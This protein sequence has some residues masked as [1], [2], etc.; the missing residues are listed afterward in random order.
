MKKVFILLLTIGFLSSGFAQERATVVNGLSKIAVIRQHT[1]PSDLT[2]PMTN[3]NYT[4][5]GVIKDG[6]LLGDETEIIETVYDLQ[7]NAN[8]SNRFWVWEDG[9][10]AATCTRG[11]ENPTGFA[12]PDRGT[13]YNYFDGTAWG[14]KPTARIETKRTGWPN[15]APWGE[16][17]EIVVSH[18]FN[19]EIVLNHRENKGTGPW[20]QFIYS[21]PG[22]GLQPAWPRVV[23]SGPDNNYLNMFYNT[24]S[25]YQG[26]TTA[27][28]YSRY[29]KD[30]QTWDIQD[31]VLE[32]VGSDYYLQ[33][34]ADDY[35][36]ASKGNIVVLLGSSAWFDLFMMKSTDMGETWEKTIIWEHPYPFFDFNTTLMPDT[37][38]SVDNSANLAI[39]DNGMVHVVWG[40]GRVARLAAAPPD[41][42]FYS[43]WPYTDGI[44][45]WNE[46]MGQI[47]EAD[48]PHHTMMP[49]YLESL[50]MLIGW[51]QDV[52]N[53]GFI[54]DFEGTAETPFGV[55]RSLGIS[56]MPTIAIH[57]G[58]IALA[59]ASTTETYVTADGLYNYKHI[60]TRFSY[61][62]G[63]TWGTFFDLQAGN[64][65]HLY[66]ECIYPV[67]A[68]NTSPEG[69]FQLI[70][71]ADNIPGLFLDED[72]DPVI[73]RV[74]HNS[75]E[76]TVGVNDPKP[77]E[78]AL[79]V[80]QSY[81]NPT[82]GN[83][84]V[85]VEITQPNLVGIEVFNLTGQ[86][87]LTIPAK[88]LQPGSHFL[89]FDASGLNSGV[90]FYTVTAGNETATRKMIVK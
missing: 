10:M 49:E 69:A 82:G 36:M 48:N 84:Q 46:S 7:S 28:L 67:L 68:P 44:G 26:Q 83:T 89:S 3:H 52:N 11:V 70:Y 65:F 45:Y 55:Y 90:Y 81:P 19:V 60:W 4:T 18:N 77:V 20:Q 5:P 39:D 51:T 57:D 78:T 43:Y 54:F 40:I 76:F 62:L 80:S 66:D 9:T 33:I 14:P 79:S 8:L 12:F 29:S 64:I 61:D 58:M 35:V 30:T 22:G 38:Y 47:P 88:S 73:N 6:R 86:K 53:S 63:Q 56:T 23:T 21:G 75:M 1:V 74:I 85:T 37:L 27:I 72:H 87:V 31:E 24:N 34:N 2:Y 71:Q 16:T 17:G 42:G 13:G 25:V 41:P 59:Y 15:I 32:G 50:G